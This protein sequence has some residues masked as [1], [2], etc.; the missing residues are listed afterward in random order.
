MISHNTTHRQLDP[1]GTHYPRAKASISPQKW[2]QQA[3]PKHWHL[4]KPQS[5]KSLPDRFTVVRF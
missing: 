4:P 3:P 1:I 5:S 2:K